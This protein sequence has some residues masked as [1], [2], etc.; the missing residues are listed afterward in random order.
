[1]F[2]RGKRYYMQ[3]LTGSCRNKRIFKRFRY[4]FL[5]I[6]PF[7]AIIFRMVFV[8]PSTAVFFDL[9][10]DRQKTDFQNHH[11]LIRKKHPPKKAT[12]TLQKIY[13]R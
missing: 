13:K 4:S 1:M 9:K 7:L 2:G 3:L 6:N 12:C 11:T 10:S 5:G 8:L